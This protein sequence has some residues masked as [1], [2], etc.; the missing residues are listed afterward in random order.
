M[1]QD[2]VRR[3]VRGSMLGIEMPSIDRWSERVAV[4]LGQNP[5]PFTG[6]GTN[7]FIVGTGKKRLLID[8][9]DGRAEY[10][11]LVERALTGLCGGCRIE[12]IAVT[13]AH[14]DHIGGVE[15]VR[16]QHGAARVWKK[17]AGDR[18]RGLPVEPI[19]EGDEI[20]V[21]GATL[22][23]LWTPGHS[24]DHL[25]F[26]LPQERAL[27]TGD[28]ILGAG[29]TVIPAEGNVADYIA[30]LERLLGLDIS[31]IYPGHGPPIRNAHEKIRDY[32]AHRRLR[33]QQILSVLARG[34]S[35]VAEIVAAIYTDVP[36]FLHPAAALSVEA[37]LRKLAAEGRAVEE[38]SGWRLK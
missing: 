30:S 13:H 6:P 5:G 28:L 31:V 18:D 19:T 8:T 23:A 34:P 36:E 25:C 9:G 1:G 21:E 12:T 16:G 15:T 2:E 17:P 10:G 7:T 3:I 35:L 38:P 24:P 14:P 20:E 26:Y 37:H 4:V 33:E 27:F 11:D 22:R 32:I 29:T